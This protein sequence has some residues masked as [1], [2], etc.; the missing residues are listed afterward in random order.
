M[1]HRNYENAVQGYNAAKG[2]LE[3]TKKTL[4]EH[5]EELGRQEVEEARL[6]EK[7]AELKATNERLHSERKEFTR[8]ATYLT[9]L[10][11]QSRSSSSSSSEPYS[12][13]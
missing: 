8:R 9:G 2:Q 1:F 13:T 7:M 11:V 10:K 4:R 6:E 5:T 12:R 3:K